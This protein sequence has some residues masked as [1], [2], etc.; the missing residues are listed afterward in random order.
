MIEL[1]PARPELLEEVASG[2]PE[3]D[4][5]ELDRCG[6]ETPLQAIESSVE[7]SEEAHVGMWGGKARFV[8]GIAP[9]QGEKPEEVP[10]VGI[11]W[12]LGQHAPRELAKTF[13]RMSHQMFNKWHERYPVM[14]NM[15]DADN[16]T[17]Q[18]WVM[19]LGMRPLA[20]RP[21]NGFPFIEFGI[22]KPC[23]QQPSA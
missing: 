22:I 13:M 11:P 20:C 12:F 16:T 21:I 3:H 17:S 10:P 18:R 15:L 8:T 23:V 4:R 19:A 6:W 1:V 9:W 14:S 5:V 7:S 2:L